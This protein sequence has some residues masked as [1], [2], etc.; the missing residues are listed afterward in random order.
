[1]ASSDETLD[2][3]G[4]IKAEHSR[5]VQQA[6]QWLLATH[7]A[8]PLKVDD[9]RAHPRMVFNERIQILPA[10]AAEPSIGFARDLSA[11]GIAFLSTVALPLEGVVLLLPQDGAPLRLQ[12]LVVR[13]TKIM[14]GLFDI[15]A[16]FLRVD[17][18]ES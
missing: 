6:I 3:S 4:Q 12:S 13:C 1:M 9:R 14:D 7:Q 15:G 10:G 2:Y 16:R 18:Q 17:E 11:G 8:A 5:Q